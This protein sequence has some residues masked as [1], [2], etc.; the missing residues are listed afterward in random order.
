MLLSLVH[1]IQ[2]A[3]HEKLVTSAL[4][5]DIKSAFN[6]VSVNK[7]IQTCQEIELPKSL[8][9]WIQ[10]FITDRSIQLTFNKKTQK[11]TAIEIGIL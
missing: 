1:D 7:L 5:L 6:H 10:S 2:L 11:K 4:F 9:T 8:I 3:K